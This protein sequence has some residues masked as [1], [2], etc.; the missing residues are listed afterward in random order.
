MGMQTTDLHA[1]KRQRSTTTPAPR[2]CPGCKQTQRRHSLLPRH[3]KKIPG[4][5]K[6]KC[7][8]QCPGVSATTRPPAGGK[9]RN[10]VRGYVVRAVVVG[11]AQRHATRDPARWCRPSAGNAWDAADTARYR[12]TLSPTPTRTH[13]T[14]KAAPKRAGKLRRARV[15]APLRQ[16]R[17]PARRA[18]SRHRPTPQR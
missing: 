11:G 6:G 5:G 10:P 1:A 9:A 14:P 13:A 4:W 12:V 17:Q 15:R 3:A 2:V 7:N 8:H 18:S 16:R